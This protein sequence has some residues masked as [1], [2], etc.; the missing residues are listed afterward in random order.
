MC[1]RFGPAVDAARLR[2]LCG[3]RSEVADTV[4]YLVADLLPPAYR[5]VYADAAEG[6]RARQAAS[7]AAIAG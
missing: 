7:A 2:A 6:T 1:A 4:G 5:G 3:R